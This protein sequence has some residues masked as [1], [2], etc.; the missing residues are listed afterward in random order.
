[1][2]LCLV[3]QCSGMLIKS[4]VADGLSKFI[5]QLYGSNSC[6]LNDL[7]ILIVLILWFK[8]SDD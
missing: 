6:I 8:V 5:T 3:D 4:G 2:L 7:F 1:M